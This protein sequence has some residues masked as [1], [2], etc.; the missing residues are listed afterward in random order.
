M[1]IKKSTNKQLRNE[2]CEHHSN[3][4]LF[5]TVMAMIGF[6]VLMFVYIGDH[7]PSNIGLAQTASKYCAAAFW[8]AAAFTSYNAVRKKRKYLIEYIIYMLVLGFGLF[9]MYSMPDFVYEMIKGTYF[10]GNWARGVFKVLSVSLVIYS[11]VSIMYHIVLATP[12]KKKK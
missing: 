4:A 11:L 5:T 1:K 10:G 8:V 12:A 3:L 7:N 2:R 6:V 9:F